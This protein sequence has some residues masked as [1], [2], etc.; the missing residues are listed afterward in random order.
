MNK[1]P[2][3]VFCHCPQ[4][5]ALKSVPLYN[6]RCSLAPLLICNIFIHPTSIHIR[7]HWKP[8]DLDHLCPPFK[9]VEAIKAFQLEYKLTFSNRISP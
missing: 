3:V 8:F 7:N 9:M 6:S 1:M 2:S 5:C 4:Y